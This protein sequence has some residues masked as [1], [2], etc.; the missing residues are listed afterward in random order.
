MIRLYLKL[1]LSPVELRNLEETISLLY[2]KRNIRQ[3]GQLFIDK[4]TFIDFLSQEHFV[5]KM[6]AGNSVIAKQTLSRVR[7]SLKAQGGGQ[8][9]L[10]TIMAPYIDEA[11]FPGQQQR[12]VNIRS[13][14][15]FL[16]V[17]A[18][19]GLSSFEV[20]NLVE[21]LDHDHNGFIGVADF[22]KEVGFTAA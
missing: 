3:N 14:K 4:P 7:L 12:V 2:A 19:R 11:L 15:V 22:D 10:E 6:D 21:Y 8:K 5:K 16:M 13:M 9:S 18:A 1:D 20:E 17:V